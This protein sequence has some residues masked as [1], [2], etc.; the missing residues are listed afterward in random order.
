MYVRMY[1]H[2]G[3][4]C[5]FLCECMRV[6]GCVVCTH[7]KAIMVGPDKPVIPGQRLFRAC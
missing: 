6:Y 3:Q 1:I 2:V 4:C 7:E 5:V